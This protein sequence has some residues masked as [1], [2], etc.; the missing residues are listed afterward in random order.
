[1]A[2]SHLL[3]TI[4]LLQSF[5]SGYIADRK[6]RSLREECQ[7]ETVGI[8]GAYSAAEV[9][10]RYYTATFFF[11]FWQR[12]ERNGPWSL[13]K[14]ARVDPRLQLLAFLR[15]INV[16]LLWGIVRMHSAKIVGHRWGLERRLKI[17]RWIG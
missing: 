7:M 8:E 6:W 12:R 16:G 14:L 15:K 3:H 4:K 11:V 13:E 5:Q 9:H 17:Q 10:Y 1:M 2:E